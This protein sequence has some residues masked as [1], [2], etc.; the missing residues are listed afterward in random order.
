MRLPVL[1]EPVP[2]VNNELFTN[3]VDGS[4]EGFGLIAE[5]S[6]PGHPEFLYL[7]NAVILVTVIQGYL[8]LL[9]VEQLVC[10]LVL[11]IRDLRTLL[12]IEQVLAEVEFI[13]PDFF[14]QVIQ[15]RLEEDFAIVEIEDDDPEVSHTV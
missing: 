10:L 8:V 3:Q 11:P 2:I 13:Q 4:V 9:L 6:G 15:L 14:L 1:E 5:R 7:H 12:D